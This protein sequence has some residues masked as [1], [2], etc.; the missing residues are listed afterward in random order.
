MERVSRQYRHL[1]IVWFKL[2]LLLL[3]L[4]FYMNTPVSNFVNLIN[5]D[6][7]FPASTFNRRGST[8][9]HKG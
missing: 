6:I 3:L 8:S 9:S 7:H 2:F 1:I 5:S 4:F